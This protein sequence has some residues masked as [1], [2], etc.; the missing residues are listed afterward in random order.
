M[1]P[2][3]SICFF[4]Q[5]RSHP[6]NQLPVRDDKPR[7]FT[8]S[9]HSKYP[10]DLLENRTPLCTPPLLGSRRSPPG[11]FLLVLVANAV[12]FVVVPVILAVSIQKS[13]IYF[14]GTATT[15]RP[16]PPFKRWSISTALSNARTRTTYCLRLDTH[17]QDPQH[18]RGSRWRLQLQVLQ[19]HWIHHDKRR[20][21]L[22]RHWAFAATINTRY[23][24]RFSPSNCLKA[25]DVT[26]A[27]KRKRGLLYMK[28]LS[29]LGAP[30]LPPTET[31]NKANK[32]VWSYPG[33]QLTI[34]FKNNSSARVA[35]LHTVWAQLALRSLG[36]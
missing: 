4:P 21:G 24:K 29:G 27:P 15:I 25:D 30:S 32:N 28:Y 34:I 12:V 35:M 14:K 36:L 3:H 8:G 13:T 5:T 1:D 22:R 2:R 18:S 11:F 31:V 6:A 16:E 19:P 33:F 26:K 10:A 9:Q 20:Q 17:N 7:L 23:K